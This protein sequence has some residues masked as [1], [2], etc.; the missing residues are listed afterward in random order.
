MQEIDLTAYADLKTV[1]LVVT[2]AWVGLFFFSLAM[3]L[4]CKVP[5]RTGLHTWLTKYNMMFSASIVVAVLVCLVIATVDVW[6]LRNSFEGIISDYMRFN[7]EVGTEGYYYGITELKDDFQRLRTLSIHQQNVA[8]QVAYRLSTI[9]ISPETLAPAAGQSSSKVEAFLSVH[10]PGISKLLASGI[11][12][13]REQLRSDQEEC[14]RALERIIYF[15]TRFR[16][17][18]S[19]AV[20]KAKSLF[21]ALTVLVIL[22]TFFLSL[23]FNGIFKNRAVKEGRSNW[24]LVKRMIGLITLFVVVLYFILLVSMLLTA[25]NNAIWATKDVFKTSKMPFKGIAQSGPTDRQ[26]AFHQR[27]NLFSKI[28]NSEEAK[29]SNSVVKLSL[30]E[31]EFGRLFELN[32]PKED[33]VKKIDENIQNSV[34]GPILRVQQ[35]RIYDVIWS[36]CVLLYF[37][38]FWIL[39]AGFGHLFISIIVMT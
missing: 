16:G 18:V 2:I 33:L 34:F 28:I 38:L 15:E 12:E 26:I 11:A 5:Y 19:I 29:G 3:R 31:A 32:G 23:C 14:D 27:L 9:N 17:C 24:S 10:W 39:V 7:P 30:F 20:N 4:M 22:M 6:K 21:I 8:D 37:T 36:L 25:V 1:M 13:R 35:Q